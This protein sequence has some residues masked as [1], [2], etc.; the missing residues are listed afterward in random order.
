MITGKILRVEESTDGRKN[1]AIHVEF[2]EDGK[3]IAPDWI[4]WAQFQNF[5]GMAP[6][7]IREWIRINVESQIGFY[8]KA[9]N[10]QL[11]ND[12]FIGEID[13]LVGSEFAVDSVDVPMQQSK[14]ILTP[15][16]VSIAS[17]GQLTVKAETVIEG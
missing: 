4:L 11:L 15:Y 14:V 12:G 3:T 8:I 6:Q 5:L 1:I 16:V 2:S 10:R 13:K 9:K 17:D 7:Q